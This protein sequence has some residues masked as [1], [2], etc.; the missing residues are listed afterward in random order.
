MLAA[1]QAHAQYPLDKGHDA[2][3]LHEYLTQPHQQDLL[4]SCGKHIPNRHN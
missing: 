3:P 4:Y 1:S 2:P